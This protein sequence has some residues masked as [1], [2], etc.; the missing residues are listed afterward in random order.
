MRVGK[1]KGGHGSTFR[2]EVLAK[3]LASGVTNQDEQA[4]RDFVPSSVEIT[5]AEHSFPTEASWGQR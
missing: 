3:Q 4:A 1:A 5:K 2:D